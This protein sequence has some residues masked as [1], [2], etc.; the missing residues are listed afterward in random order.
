MT[1]T[2]LTVSDASIR[3]ML[4]YCS[5][6]D[7]S[8]MCGHR[9]QSRHLIQSCSWDSIQ[10]L[11]DWIRFHC[12][13]PMNQVQN[14]CC[15][16]LPVYSQC[17]SRRNKAA[18]RKNAAVQDR[19]CGSPLRF[20]APSWN[21][22]LHRGK[23]ADPKLN[24]SGRDANEGQCENRLLHFVQAGETVFTKERNHQ[25][26]D[27]RQWLRFLHYISSLCEACGSQMSPMWIFDLNFW[28]IDRQYRMAEGIALKEDIKG[29]SS[30]AALMPQRYH[31]PSDSERKPFPGAFKARC[32]SER[33]QT[34]SGMRSPHLTSLRRSCEIHIQPTQN[35]LLLTAISIC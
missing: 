10:T 23:A 25:E 4:L 6:E 26:N 8:G 15:L 22:S 13:T 9:I 28:E 5:M 34:S 29:F 3:D 14:Y 21:V 18:K 27:T 2:Y 1:G 30:P 31:A 35:E 12:I 7:L 24:L 33:I 16:I 32:R 20:W 19:L 17:Y 11:S